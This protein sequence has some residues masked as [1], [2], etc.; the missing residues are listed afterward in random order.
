MRH[1]RA[2]IVRQHV[3]APEVEMAHQRDL[4]GGHRPLRVVGVVGGAFRLGGVAIAA[5]VGGDHGEM[6]G[7]LA[8]ELVP[9]DMRLWVA[10]LQEQAR[11]AAADA[12]G[13][14]HAVDVTL[15]FLESGEHGITPYD[16]CAHPKSHSARGKVQSV[17]RLFMKCVGRPISG[18]R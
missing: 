5:Q 7:Q 16:C 11:P 4:V 12:V 17:V 18:L 8:G 15:V 14:V 10:V 1:A 6:L 3:E 9:D 13:N 2:A